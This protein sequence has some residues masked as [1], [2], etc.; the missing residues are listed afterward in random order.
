MPPV[1]SPSD[2]YLDVAAAYDA[3]FDG[4]NA[5]IAGYAMRCVAGPLLVLG[6]GTGRV[7]R[8]L[9]SGRP[10]T[11]LD[12]SAAMIDRAR[13][14]APE[15]IRWV[16]GDMTDFELGAFGEVIIP[17]ASFAFLP[18]RRARS[19]CLA[20]CR[21]ALAAKGPL[22]IDLPAPDPRLMADAHT[23]ERVA[24]EGQADGVSVRRT[25]EVFRS[26]LLGNLRLVDRYY[27]DGAAP[28]ESVLALHLSTPD[29]LEWMLEANGFYVEQSWGDHVGGP[30]RE[31]CDRLLIRALPL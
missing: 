10:V 14:R 9:A 6:C 31:G 27:I 12:R 23:P 5:D 20:R 28:I 17:N 15:G 16:V 4:A 3:E 30:V 19:A 26:P 25:R 22:T 13:R 21:G 11:G 18:D 1:V 8:G 24:W 2:P 29:E 7:C